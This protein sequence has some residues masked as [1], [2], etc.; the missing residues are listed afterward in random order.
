M[1]NMNGKSLGLYF[2][3]DNSLGTVHYWHKVLGLRLGL[4]LPIMYCSSAIILII[5]ES[6]GEAWLKHT[7]THVPIQDLCQLDIT[8]SS[9]LF[10][11]CSICAFWTHHSFQRKFRSSIHHIYPP[12]TNISTKE[13]GLLFEAVCWHWIVT[14][15][16]RVVSQFTMCH[17]LCL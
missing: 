4:Y 16:N 5:M 10:C 15:V 2:K 3:T 6:S 8:R 1:G 13:K 14:S 17:W 9:C 7:I 11:S 12:F